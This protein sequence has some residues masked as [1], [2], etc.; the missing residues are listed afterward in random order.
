M[1]EKYTLGHVGWSPDYKAPRILERLQGTP[2]AGSLPASGSGARGAAPDQTRDK[3]T[4]SAPPFGGQGTG[5]LLRLRDHLIRE[6]AYWRDLAEAQKD[7]DI[8]VMIEEVS[9]L[10]AAVYSTVAAQLTDAAGLPRP[11]SEGESVPACSMCHQEYYEGLKKDCV[12]GKRC[13]FNARRKSD[14]ASGP[15]NAEPIH[16]EKNA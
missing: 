15:P 6:A 16:G 4:S 13:P 14:G 8:R 5:S 2:P 9:V 7:S 1:N 11:Q 10:R 3:N 12:M